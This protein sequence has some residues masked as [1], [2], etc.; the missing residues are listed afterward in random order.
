VTST[1]TYIVEKIYESPM[2]S[3]STVVLWV[4]RHPPLPA[5][6][7]ELERR[8]SGIV[9]Y[10]MSGVI[11]SAEAVV[12]A[13]KKLNA[14]VIVPVLPLSMIARLAELSKQNKFTVLIAKMNNIATTKS[15]EEAPRLV[16]EKPEAR[17]VATYADGVA[18][19][20]EF[21]RF[22]KLVEVKLVTEP[23]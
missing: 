7:A 23:L 3:R 13:A 21:E 19:V 8:F 16:A 2:P 11:P 4:S 22:E 9:V 1:T 20:L 18:R 5:Q 15:V 14:N 10:Q 12:E 6:I 17:T